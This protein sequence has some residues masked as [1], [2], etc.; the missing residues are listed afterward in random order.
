MPDWVIVFSVEITNRFRVSP[1]E[2]HL[3]VPS[4]YSALEVDGVPPLY[5]RFA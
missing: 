4:Q 1:E 3:N 2:N 5:M